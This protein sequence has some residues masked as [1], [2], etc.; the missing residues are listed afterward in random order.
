[1]LFIN[2]YVVSDW[3]PSC[4]LSHLRMVFSVGILEILDCIGQSLPL[5]FYF[6]LSFIEVLLMNNLFNI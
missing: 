5:F 1:M 4:I 6:L 3:Y 2:F